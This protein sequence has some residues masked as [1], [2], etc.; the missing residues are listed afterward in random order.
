MNFT[1]QNKEMTQKDAILV[2]I[3]A[4]ELAQQ[5]GVWKLEE[6]AIIHNAVSVFTK[7]PQT[8][9]TQIKST[10]LDSISEEQVN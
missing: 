9:Q 4:V 1:Q 2:L 10:K 8:P 7:S 5:R 3:N 6:A